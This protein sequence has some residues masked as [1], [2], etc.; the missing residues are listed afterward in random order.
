MKVAIVYFDRLPMFR[1][2][3]QVLRHSVSVHMP[4]TPVE[5]INPSGSREKPV[6][7]KRLLDN[8]IKMR[9]WH[10]YLRCE[11][12]DQRI[13]LLDC[14]MM[15]TGSLQEVF[16][17]PFDIAFTRSGRKKE[18]IN[19]GAVFVRTGPAVDSFMDRW[20]DTAE[21]MYYD[22]AFHNYWRKT[23]Q[24][25]GISQASL[26]HLLEGPDTGVRIHM[27]PMRQY[28]AV[29]KDHKK[30]DADTKLVHIKGHTPLRRA[31]FKRRK[32]RRIRG[33]VGKLVKIWKQY[34]REFRNNR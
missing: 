30:F 19:T 11:P 33:R 29:G 25:W 24:Y 21:A 14:D 32:R 34:E 7:G 2:M 13:I 3:L 4:G 10:R 17:H 28:N 22:P 20:L 31:L 8:M 5:L 18:P 1:K 23:K 6:R 16:T 12:P 26:G 9:Q 15:L 27:L